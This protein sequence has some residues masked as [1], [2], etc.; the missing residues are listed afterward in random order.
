M[1]WELISNNIII[2]LGYL[3]EES[4]SFSFSLDHCTINCRVTSIPSSNQFQGPIP[5]GSLL[6]SLLP[7]VMPPCYRFLLLLLVPLMVYDILGTV[8]PAIFSMC[9]CKL[10]LTYYE[11]LIVFYL[12]NGL[13]RVKVLVHPR[14]SINVSPPHFPCVSCLDHKTQSHT[15]QKHGLN[16]YELIGNHN[17]RA[18]VWVYHITLCT[19]E[20]DSFYVGIRYYALY[21]MK[22]SCTIVTLT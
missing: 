3:S 10:L 22:S 1:F 2:W 6:W 12:W 14:C 13:K 16:V 15:H 5:P 4:P 18:S 21:K 20:N 7:K 11:I 9:I 17:M 8:L 19:N